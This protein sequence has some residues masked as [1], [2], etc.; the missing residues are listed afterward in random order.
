MLLLVVGQ[1]QATIKKGELQ[2]IVPLYPSSSL[3]L[4]GLQALAS[5]QLRSA[6]M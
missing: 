4:P 1:K 2:L 6:R 5:H 3:G